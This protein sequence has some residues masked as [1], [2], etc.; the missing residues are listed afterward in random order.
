MISNNHILLSQKLKT[1]IMRN[2]LRNFVSKPNKIQKHCIL[3]AKIRQ[4]QDNLFNFIKDSF[5]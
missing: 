1:T 4:S 2:N 3:Q 5:I